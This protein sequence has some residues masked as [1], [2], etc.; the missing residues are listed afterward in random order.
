M[1]FQN[2]SYID[3]LGAIIPFLSSGSAI[4]F[5]IEVILLSKKLRSLKLFYVL[6]YNKKL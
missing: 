6:K 2:S 1:D 4:V 3:I 5:K